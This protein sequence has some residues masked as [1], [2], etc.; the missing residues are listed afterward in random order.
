M[1]RLNRISQAPRRAILLLL[2][3]LLFSG[4]LWYFYPTDPTPELLLHESFEWLDLDYRWDAGTATGDP[5]DAQPI[6]GRLEVYGPGHFLRT[7]DQFPT[8]LTILLE[9]SVTNGDVTNQLYPAENLTDPDFSITIDELDLTIELN[10]YRSAPGPSRADTVR[11]LDRVQQELVTPPVSVESAGVTRG[12]LTVQLT[13]A[14]DGLR[15]DVEVPEIG[16]EAS[17]LA[18]GI[19]QTDSAITIEVSG[20][21]DDPR[22]L[23]E[24]F[25]YRLPL[26]LGDLQ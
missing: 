8:D 16:L 25:F 6:N 2:V 23:E 10:L 26:N 21:R 18:P 11:I 9:W 4:C 20:L 15:V 12:R 1:R 14:G 5:G 22:S 17:A 24:L 19:E 7:R 13:R 3:P